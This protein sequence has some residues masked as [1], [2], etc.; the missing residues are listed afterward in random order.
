MQQVK[1]SLGSEESSILSLSRDHRGCFS[2][3]GMDGAV[4]LLDCA[5]GS[6]LLAGP[7]TRAGLPPQPPAW[8]HLL[9]G[10]HALG[11]GRS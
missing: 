2:L 1:Q 9:P 6:A 10:K 7:S 3:C 5:A 4:T 8:A 11:L